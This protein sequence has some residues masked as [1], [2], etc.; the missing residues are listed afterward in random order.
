MAGFFNSNPYEKGII[1]VY[2]K[3]IDDVLPKYKN[4][5]FN[6]YNPYLK[7]INA[8]EAFYADL[9]NPDN[10]KALV[11]SNK[12]T[13]DYI[14]ENLINY[15]SNIS[16]KTTGGATQSIDKNAA[17]NLQPTNYQTTNY[18]PKEQVADF[19][20]PT[21]Y[22]PTNYQP[23]NY[24]TT[25][26]QTTNY[27]TTNYQ[28]KEQV[29]DFLQT[30]EKQSIK[31][32]FSDYFDEC[33]Y[34]YDN[35]RLNNAIVLTKDYVTNESIRPLNLIILV[36]ELA[37]AVNDFE[38]NTGTQKDIKLCVY[39]IIQWYLLHNETKGIDLKS[40]DIYLHTIPYD[41]KEFIKEIN[42][43]LY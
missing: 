35:I 34:S 19:L 41:D 32:Y 4:I 21:N 29:A 15:I 16:N 5:S 11:E 43:Y 26:Y 22:Q 27:Q 8:I 30:K 2:K 13:L 17:A 36:T 1:P 38:N 28:P 37:E 39:S 14:F 42:M 23:T 6:N 33:V 20:Q 9:T 18:Q 12:R 10:I 31:Q 24:Q 3:I 7:T 25:N 40:Y